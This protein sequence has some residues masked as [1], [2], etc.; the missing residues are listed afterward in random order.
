MSCHDGKGRG[1]S[2]V[3]ES[4]EM[5]RIAGKAQEARKQQGK[6]PHRISEGDRPCGHLGFRLPIP[7]PGVSD[8]CSCEPSSRGN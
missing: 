5:P 8:L 6:T 4:Q 3:T 7:A 2:G 1:W